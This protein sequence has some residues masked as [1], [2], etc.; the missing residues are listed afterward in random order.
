MT[1]H[2]ASMLAAAVLLSGCAVSTGTRVDESIGPR[3][4]NIVIG[5]FNFSESQVLAE[6]YGQALEAADFEVDVLAN[7]GPREIMEPSLEQEQIDLTIEYLGAALTFL[8]PDALADR[9]TR[10]GI[11]ESLRREFGSRGLLALS[12]AP[13]ENRNEIVVTQETAQKHRLSTITDLQEVDSEFTFGGP[14]ECPARP[15][16]LQG[17]GGLYQLEFKAFVPL[18][19]GGPTT[20]ASLENGDV[21]V[22]LLFTTNPAIERGRLVALED[23]R[24]LQPAENIVPIVRRDLAEKHGAPFV[25]AIDSVSRL[26]TNDELRS[27]NAGVEVAH[28]APRDVASEWLTGKGLL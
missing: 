4:K 2:V 25:A 19:A 22:A 24:H 10:R 27:L 23:D 26:L 9:G 28:R 14:S 6:V 7:V 16:C 18:D 17:L 15:F 1:R 12:P 8:D 13:G 21:D 20:L 3:S 5:A 11:Y